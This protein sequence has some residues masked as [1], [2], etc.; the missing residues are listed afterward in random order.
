MGENIY[1]PCYLINVLNLEY[2]NNSP[3]SVRKQP[4]WRGGWQSSIWKDNDDHNIIAIRGMQIKTT[5]TC[6]YKPTRTAKNAQFKRL[7]IPRAANDEEQLDSHTLVVRMYNGRTTLQFLSF[8]K[9]NQ[10]I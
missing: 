4:S 9:K 8:F 7:I 5:V 3:N 10:D 2:M 1:K 6:H